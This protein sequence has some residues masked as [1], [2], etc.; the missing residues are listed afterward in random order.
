MPEAIYLVSGPS[1][2]FEMML[3]EVWERAFY[4]HYIPCIE[5]LMNIKEQVVLQL[6]TKQ[7]DD[8][9]LTKEFIKMWE[10]R[11]WNAERLAIVNRTNTTD[12]GL[13]ACLI[14]FLF[15]EPSVM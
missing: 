7:F 1:Q 11:K 9:G 13:F 12:T 8:L 5:S 14:R 2:P 3:K 10:R 15:K 4:S 6:K